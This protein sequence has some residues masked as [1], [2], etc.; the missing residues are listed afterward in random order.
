M[1]DIDRV[2]YPAGQQPINHDSEPA[3]A[4]DAPGMTVPE[5]HHPVKAHEAFHKRLLTDM[6]AGA[7]Y[8]PPLS[9]VILL[10]TGR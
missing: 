8:P 3:A 2:D 1:R 10:G 9:D 5:K 7:V 4:D 6:M